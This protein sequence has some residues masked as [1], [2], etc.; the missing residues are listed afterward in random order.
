MFVTLLCESAS[1][2]HQ[3]SDNPSNSNAVSV[4]TPSGEICSRYAS[5]TVR[6]II[7]RDI[8]SKVDLD[9]LGN[10]CILNPEF[11]MYFDQE[12]MKEVSS[13]IFFFDEMNLNSFLTGIG[14]PKER[15]WL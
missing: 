14:A 11:D 4:V 8:L 1:Q 12:N 10:K 13:L 3:M 6:S 7:N 5:R 15:I 9:S 2:E